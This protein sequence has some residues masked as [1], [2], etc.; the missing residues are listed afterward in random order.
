ML[1]DLEAVLAAAQKADRRAGTVAQLQLVARHVLGQGIAAG[2]EHGVGLRAGGA[3]A[4]DV[5]DRPPVLFDDGVAI[6]E[7]V[8]R[9]PRQNRVE[10]AIPP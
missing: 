2:I 8:Q 9:L 4:L 6:V 7:V 10:Q 3:V 1:H 5:E